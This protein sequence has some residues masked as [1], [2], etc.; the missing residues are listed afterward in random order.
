MSRTLLLSFR[1]KSSVTLSFR[2]KSRNLKTFRLRSRWQWCPMSFRLIYAERDRHEA[3]RSHFMSFRA[4]SRNLNLN[5]KTFRLHS[6]WQKSIMPQ[7]V[8]CHFERSRE[9]LTYKKS[10]PQEVIR[11][12]K[13]R[14][15][16]R[17]G[18]VDFLCHVKF[19]E[20]SKDL[21]TT[22]KATKSIVPRAALMSFFLFSY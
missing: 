14:S 22:L 11:H 17:D 13:K 4:K 10:L 8:P 3:Q 6:R 21:S 12:G 19:T 9:I 15:D 5:K 18:W 7:S 1:A 16:C 2:A 20:K